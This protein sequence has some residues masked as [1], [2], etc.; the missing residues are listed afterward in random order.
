M[1]SRPLRCIIVAYFLIF[2]LSPAFGQAM[3]FDRL[4]V[5]DGL[6]QS[7]V[8]CILQDRLGYMW[9]GTQD[10]L[11]RYDGYTFTIFKH[12]PV[13]SLS[14]A[15]N[16]IISLYEDRSGTLWVGTMGNFHRFDSRTQKFTRISPDSLN[17]STAR[18]NSVFAIYQDTAGIRWTGI[19][20]RGITRLDTRTGEKREYKNDP[21]N[22]NSLSDNRVYSIYQ[23]R[24]G[25][26][27]FGTYGGLNRFDP[28]TERFSVYKASDKSNS[29]SNNWVWPVFEDSRGNLWVGTGK[30]GLNMMD[31]KTGSFKRFRHSSTDQYS[32][33]DDY[34][35]CI[36]E[37]AG[38]VL[39]VGT[40]NGLN[41]HHPLSQAFR[42]YTSIQDD[43][44]SLVD[45]RVKCMLVDRAGYCWVGTSAGLD[46][47][48]SRTGNFVHYSNNP[49][50]P[51]SLG[52]DEIQ[53]L[54]ESRD[55]TL[56]VGTFGSGLDRL[57]RATGNFTHFRRDPAKP[58]SLSD[59]SVYAL[60]EDRDGILWVGTYRGG[61]NRFDKSTGTFTS[62]KHREDDPQSI[63]GNGAWAL[64]EDRAGTLWVG[65]LGSGLNRFDK[66]AETFEHF[67]HDAAIPSSISNDNVLAMYEDKSGRFWIATLGGLNLLDR[68]TGKFT[69]Y[70]EKDGLANDNVF[71]ILEDGKGRLWL[72]TNKG[73]S[74]FDPQSG[75]FRNFDVSDGLQSNE[76]NQSAFAMNGRT[77]EMFFGGI[78]GFNA[79]HPDQVSDNPYKPPVVISSFYRYNTDD[80][81][82]KPIPEIGIESRDQIE[83]SYKDN[84]ATV[85]FA[86]LSYYNTYKNQY[87]YKLEGF[88]EN[89][90][91]LGTV[92]QTTF[93]NLD[94]GEYTLRVRGSNND[95]V[96][97]EEGAA[98]R[99]TVT[100]PWWKTNIAYA[101][102]GIL[103][104]G[105]LYGLRRFEIN[106][107][108]QK[109]RM[110]ESELRAKAAEA[111]KRALSAENERKSKEL[112]EA[113]QL[114]LSML[115]KEI[116]QVPN[117]EIA[118]FMRTA[119][120][121]GGD[122]Y[123]FSKGADGTWSIAC[124]DATGHGM[125][126]G[127]VVT[128]MKG[129]FTSDAARLDIKTFFNHCS[130]SI[131]EIKMGRLLMAFTML[132]VQE[133]KISFS[134]AGMPPVFICRRQKGEIDEVL[135]KGMPLGAMKNFPY[136]VH[137][138]ELHAGDI[139]LMLS[140]G[141]PEQ[142]NVAG[143]MFDYPR[144]REKL[145]EREDAAPQEI[146][147]HLV[148]ACDEW[149]KGAVQ[150]DDITMIVL[151]VAA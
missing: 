113:R 3:R 84:V 21:A 76:F 132:R 112:E 108:E 23:D 44:A 102:Y 31:R 4:N 141:L 22:P 88:S 29:I 139:V 36:Y 46:R 94:P 127:T 143:E 45:N 128:L 92:N 121:V 38:G 53:S 13:D 85:G 12:D 145:K 105:V 18:G 56:W 80:T 96:W 15:E 106:Q 79:F 119:T 99:L 5:T 61:L 49:A 137:E 39:W 7:G 78:A 116:P 14:L 114:Q 28:R 34:V 30:G 66:R 134:A 71:G 90:I 63:S 26:L 70:R 48:D 47:F 82:G 110:R 101:S 83:L 124:G 67:K 131:K 54:L 133:K 140:D 120:E 37:D 69:H 40:N 109:T 68:S 2:S 43:P 104:I 146:I 118:V 111:E 91:Q 57:D 33:S 16:F 50:N 1:M 8:T 130:K 89:W 97:N 77:G 129:L 60:L 74:R 142:K 52:S 9:F 17:L 6:P 24:E 75:T 86:A 147:N 93:T 59:N 123:D 95:G 32:L 10:G 55:G 72:S 107:R 135:L 35:F 148:S 73:L 149:M 115:P 117:I 150:E 62:Y 144:V 98:L 27:W 81:E 58:G 25:I 87:A 138:E 122:Y 42:H 65:T 151:K 20:G 100:P 11:S 136:A 64:Y 126:A 51:R 19:I 125:Q 41:R 103:F